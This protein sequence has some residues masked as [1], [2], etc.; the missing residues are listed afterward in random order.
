[1]VLSLSLWLS[2]CDFFSEPPVV[3]IGRD[4]RGLAHVYADSL[5]GLYYGYGYSIA[6][7]RLFQLDS[8]LHTVWGESA[9]LFGSD[10]VEIDKHTLKTTDYLAIHR[11]FD[12]L[13]KNEPQAFEMIEGFAAGLNAYIQWCLAKPGERLPADFKRLK[14]KPRLWTTRDVVMLYVG[15][16]AYRYTD[17]N[18]EMTNLNLL[19][20]LEK[21]HGREKAWQI[22]NE[23][24]PLYT[25]NSPTTVVRDLTAPRDR[26][27]HPARPEYL[28]DLAAT[29]WFGPVYDQDA[30]P[31]QD[32]SDLKLR[33]NIQRAGQD[34]RLARES[35]S[36][37]W[38][39][40]APRL[41]DAQAV[42]VNGPQFGFANPSYVY[43]VALHGP[44]FQVFG[45][46]L[47]GYPNL[48][49]A[50]NGTIGWGSTAGFGDQV[51]IFQLPL[52]PKKPDHYYYEGQWHPLIARTHV[53]AVKGGDPVDYTTHWTD[54]GPVLAR[55]DHPKNP[56]VYV[57]RRAWQ[58]RA[59]QSLV[60]W[61]KLPFAKNIKE[62]NQ[63]LETFALS[64][65]FYYLD[66]QAQ[67]GYVH[68]GYYPRRSV[69]HD[70]RLPLALNKD[71]KDNWLELRPYSQNPKIFNP[72][73]NYLINWNNRPDPAWLNSDLW[74]VK[75]GLTDRGGIL[76]QDILSRPQTSVEQAWA[77]IEQSSYRDLH[78]SHL[79]N[80][81]EQALATSTDPLAKSLALELKDWDQSW[82][83]VD[84]DGFY[85]SPACAFMHEW[86]TILLREVFADDIPQDAIARYTTTNYP[87][88][89]I[90]PA[91]SDSLGVAIVARQMNSADK[92]YDFTNGREWSTIFNDT[93]KQ[94]LRHLRKNYGAK[95]SDWKIANPGWRFKPANFRGVPMGEKSLTGASAQMNR[96]SENNMFI[97]RDGQMVGFDVVPPGQSSE[98]PDQM[99]SFL[100]F[101]YSPL[102]EKFSV[103]DFTEV[104]TLSLAK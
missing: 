94:A 46:S 69:A 81:L 67:L 102:N 51:D 30:R 15:T 26:P 10:Y 50:H 21:L 104:T 96:G 92:L 85:D 36:N 35:A 97:V 90:G 66:T 53:I 89:D 42:L 12:R 74:W 60:Q 80:S 48:L 91:I 28:D 100:E 6:Q 16:M 37:A 54:I 78:Y 70:N 4:Q 61:L 57:K 18:E 95:I 79:Q 72:K 32:F 34:W 29:Q 14:L 25:D 63:I 84:E 64:I 2:A 13:E 55:I 103:E 17:F 101:G 49:F 40:R 19:K 45:N 27:A 82:K 33:D 75:W 65:N 93:L 22:F 71:S 56:V 76:H 24:H 23:A 59:V 9:K 11:E 38:L 68:A 62:F 52:D 99:K 43:G 7:D 39:L 8:T 58:D 98:N 88:S 44:D 20:G 77:L 87:L 31:E 83:D 5:Y 3:Q 41:S 1:M 73:E 47:Y 86:L